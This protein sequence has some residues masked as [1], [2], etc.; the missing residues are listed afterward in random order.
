M[1]IPF[2]QREDAVK[3]SIVRSQYNDLTF[4]TRP[5]D[6]GRDTTTPM[7]INTENGEMFRVVSGGGSIGKTSMAVP[8]APFIPSK[9]QGRKSKVDVDG[10]VVQ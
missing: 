1:N 2:N 4:K 6:K 5:A 9:L 8:D 7:L 10:V 3:P